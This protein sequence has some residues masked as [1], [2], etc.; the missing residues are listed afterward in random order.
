[1]EPD[2]T[3]HQARERGYRILA[4]EFTTTPAD[5][6]LLASM[7]GFLVRTGGRPAIVL[8][9][10]GHLAIYRLSAEMETG[11]QT[12]RRLKRRKLRGN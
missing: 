11:P 1:M 2:L 8:Q 10:S 6:E 7:H 3:Y 9:C 12:E 4:G 5:R